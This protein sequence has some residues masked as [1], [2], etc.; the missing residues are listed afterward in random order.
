M[1]REVQMTPVYQICTYSRA[2]MVNTVADG[3]NDRIVNG[4]NNFQE[5]DTRATSCATHESG[6]TGQ[7]GGD[8][9]MCQ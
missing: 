8:N 5:M 6:S 2:V 7:V 4:S 9:G 3:V 1:C